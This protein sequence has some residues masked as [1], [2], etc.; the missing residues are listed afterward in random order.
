MI[1]WFAKTHLS[2]SYNM[3]VVNKG[4]CNLMCL[5]NQ[6]LLSVVVNDKNKQTYRKTAGLPMEN[7]CE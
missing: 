7:T 6:F 2:W 5:E 3:H 1:G 4:L